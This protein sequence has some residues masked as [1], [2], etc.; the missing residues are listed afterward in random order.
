MPA[1]L[2][3]SSKIISD[4]IIKILY[5]PPKHSLSS[6]NG[7]KW[8][9]LGALGLHLEDSV[10]RDAI[11]AF[12]E[13][14]KVCKKIAFQD[15]THTHLEIHES[16]K[17]KVSLFH[18]TVLARYEVGNHNQLQLQLINIFSLDN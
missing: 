3:P 15:D 7:V 9:A 2:G 10:T 18:I 1:E 12:A 11:P 6:N 13:I 8:V 16:S 17:C 14:S 5:F 4:Q